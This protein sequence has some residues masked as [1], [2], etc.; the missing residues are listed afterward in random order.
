MPPMLVVPLLLV[1]LLLPPRSCRGA[2]RPPHA[3]ALQ[4][5]RLA[6][7][8]GMAYLPPEELEGRFVSHGLRLQ[9]HGATHFTRWFVA[10]QEPG[11][12][13]GP[14]WLGG[15]ADGRPQ[16]YVFLRGVSWRSADLD[17]LRVWQ[18]LA[19]ALPTP[20]LPH[21]TSPP[22]LLAAHRW[23]GAAWRAWVHVPLQGWA[24]GRA[25]QGRPAAPPL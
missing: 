6:A 8:S 12:A 1:L 15:P 24:P 2:S 16:Q 17:A 3:T 21:L 20:F 10:R 23:A 5:A 22:D 9:A 13:G 18:G 25:M 19:R 11:A 4:D 7:L 14:H